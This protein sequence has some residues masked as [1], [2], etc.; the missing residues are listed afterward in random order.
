MALS[1]RFTVAVRVP[2][3]VGVNVALMVHVPLAATELPQV[4]VTAKS[5]G[6][7]PVVVMPVIDK[8]AFPVLV[9]V[10]D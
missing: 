4:L 9:R 5:P 6:F 8:L 3:A 2:T 1:A 10:T 7:V